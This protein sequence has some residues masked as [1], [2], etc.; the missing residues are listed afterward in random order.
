MVTEN[1][2]NTGNQNRVSPEPKLFNNLF[3]FQKFI[4]CAENF[5]SIKLTD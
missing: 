5:N 2:K 3:I 1:S 4:C